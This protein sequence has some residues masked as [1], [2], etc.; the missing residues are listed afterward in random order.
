MCPEKCPHGGLLSTAP[1]AK[2]LMLSLHLK[3]AQTYS[4]GVVCPCRSMFCCVLLHVRCIVYD[5]VSPTPLA[6]SR[7]YMQQEDGAPPCK[8]N[9]M[10]WCHTD[11][12]AVAYSWSKLVQH[13]YRFAVMTEPGRF[14]GQDALMTEAI[15][16]DG[17]NIVHLEGKCLFDQ[18][19]NPA[20]CARMG[21]V[22]IFAN[23][24][25]YSPAVSFGHSAMP[26]RMHAVCW[27][28]SMR[29]SMF[30]CLRF[31]AKLLVDARSAATGGCSH[32]REFVTG[33]CC[34]WL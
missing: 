12:G 11:L 7:M 21:G 5:L 19:P 27:D 2:C 18:G 22:P 6:K 29:L 1:P 15:T 20:M 16:Q 31:E 8:V 23:I 26:D 33:L 25:Q 17:W 28:C 9:R 4:N 32:H 14:T 34:A 24:Q 3:P 30:Q 13:D 10:K